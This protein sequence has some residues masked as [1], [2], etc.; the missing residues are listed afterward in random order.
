MLTGVP[1]SRLLLVLLPV[2][3]PGHTPLRAPLLGLPFTATISN[4]KHSF[5]SKERNE[6]ILVERPSWSPPVKHCAYE[7]VALFL[8]E[9]YLKFS[10]RCPRTPTASNLAC[11]ETLSWSVSAV[12]TTHGDVVH[13]RRQTVQHIASHSDKQD[14]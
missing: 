13:G 7:V 11:K 3:C 4:N 5:V 10:G 14:S 12:A 1:L 8:L 2:K 6:N 9:F